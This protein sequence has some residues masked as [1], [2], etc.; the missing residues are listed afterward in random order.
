MRFYLQHGESP[1]DAIARI[2]REL[3]STARHDLTE[4]HRDPDAAVHAVRKSLKKLRALLRLVRPVI[5]GKAFR[6][7]DRAVHDLARQ[8]G[9]ARDSAVMLCAFD[10]LVTHFSPFL[11]EAAYA[12][13]RQSLAGRYQVAIEQHLSRMDYDRLRSELHNLE[14]LLTQLD[15]GEFSEKK[16]LGSVLKTYRQGRDELSALRD[17]PSTEHGHALRKQAKYLWYQLRL[18]RESNNTKLL[19]LIQELN[20]L[21]ELLGQDHDLAVLSATLQRQPEICCNA[22]R[23]ELV[24]GLIETRRVALLSAALRLADKIYL[25]K[26]KRFLSGLGNIAVTPLL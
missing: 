24:T 16:L 1:A 25:Q 10:Q 8:L 5:K 19:Q 15:L 6:A 14:R 18:L 4:S 13:I 17:E 20:E 23:S 11:N 9:G 22:V 21:G 26:P 3:L 7:A 2:I 12:P